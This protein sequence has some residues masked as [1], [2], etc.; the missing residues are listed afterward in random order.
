[1]RWGSSSLSSRQALEREREVRAALG[2]GDGVDLVDDHRLDAAQH[3]ARLRG[4][5]QVE[6]LR[7]GDQ[8]V[9]RRA[10]HRR[11]VALRRVAGADRD[12]EV[13]PDPAQRR[14]QVALDV[15]G[16]RLQRRD[17]DQAR[18]LSAGSTGEPVEAPQ[19]GGERLARAG[20]RGDEHV[21][22]GGDGR[23]GLRLGRGRRLERALEPVAYGRREGG[24]RQPSVEGSSVQRASGCGRPH[25]CAPGAAQ[26]VGAREGVGRAHADRARH[27]GR[28][29][30]A[31]AYAGQLARTPEDRVEHRL[32]QPPGERVL[33]AGVKAAE[34]A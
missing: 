11:A 6:R 18:V 32:G 14:A 20:G 30:S 27:L 3:L 10:A 5:H 34:R 17:V 28:A 23:P 4:E 12:R 1:M 21:L 26:R 33:L 19:E 2:R 24:Q 31:S 9:R 16:E 15:V 7:R 22:A 29:A 8:D 13:G 25:S